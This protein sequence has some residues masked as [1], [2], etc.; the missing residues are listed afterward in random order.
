MNP[1]GAH[2]GCKKKPSLPL[3]LS[4]SDIKLILYENFMTEECRLKRTYCVGSC[5]PRNWTSAFSLLRFR[6]FQGAD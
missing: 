4:D 2:A 3:S 5:A 1:V 6:G